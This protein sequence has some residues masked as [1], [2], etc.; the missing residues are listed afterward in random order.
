MPDIGTPAQLAGNGQAPPVPN[1]D[2]NALRMAIAA[3]AGGPQSAAAGG[4]GGQVPPAMQQGGDQFQQ[5]NDADVAGGGRTNKA[6]AIAN[7]LR[8]VMPIL[9][10]IAG[11]ISHAGTPQERTAAGQ[12]QVEQYGAETNRMNVS[13]EIQQRQ[14]MLE[15]TPTT[16]SNGMTLYL[17][18][19]ERASL[20]RGGLSGQEHADSAEKI[21]TGRDQTTLAVGAGHDTAHVDAA[22]IG[23][24]SR[25]G[26]QAGKV[27]FNKGIPISVL[28]PNG[29]R[30]DPNDPN[31]PADLKQHVQTAKAAYQQAQSD[32][33]SQANARGASYAQAREVQAT[34]TANGG[35]ETI[36]NM[37]D[38]NKNPGRYEPLPTGTTRTMSQM[39]GSVVPQMQ[40]VKQQVSQ[41]ADK[42]G[43]WEG[44]LNDLWVNK[45]GMDDPDFAKLD[46]NLTLLASA[47]V[48]THFGAKGGQQYTQAMIKDFREAQTAGDL[49]GRID[50][51]DSWL[52]GYAGMSPRGTTGQTQGGGQA[53]AGYE[54]RDGPQGHGYYKIKKK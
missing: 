48:R 13:S 51:A 54:E 9:G 25:Q 42:L 16:L 49:M 46:Q 8:K 47:I 31:L 32:A 44:R 34:D 20:L 35:R 33:L 53:P 11:G 12:Q 39:A 36:T 3:Q 50:S 30:L 43:P 2:P 45:T 18:P 5:P 29:E 15:R 10:G 6:A 4:P 17:N 19:A 1:A 14:S 23:A 24:N 52:R 26:A 41:L 22:Q 7:M 28:G 27:E 21:A 37:A 40:Q 38:V